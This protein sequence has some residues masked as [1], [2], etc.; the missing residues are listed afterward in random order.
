MKPYLA[1]V[2]AVMTLLTACVSKEVPV[3]QKYSDTEIRSEPYQVT[4]QYDINTPNVT[5]VYTVS[6]TEVWSSYPGIP[7]QMLFNKADDNTVKWAIVGIRVNWVK[8]NQFSINEKANWGVESAEQQT[9]KNQRI[10]VKFDKDN[11]SMCIQTQGRADIAK[12]KG[13]EPLSNDNIRSIWTM[14]QRIKYYDL[15]TMTGFKDMLDDQYSTGYIDTSTRVCNYDQKDSKMANPIEIPLDIMFKYEDW[16]LLSINSP[17]T[18]SYVWDNV[19]TG[20]HEVTKYRDVP[21]QVEKQRTVMLTKSVP[22]WEA[23]ASK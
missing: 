10:S 16:A 7:V 17:A 18:V 21:Y 13:F 1:I 20:T 22:F 12:Q 8:Q 9:P 15:I 14:P 2:V 6:H 3:I 11:V 23:G 4:E 5:P 19:T